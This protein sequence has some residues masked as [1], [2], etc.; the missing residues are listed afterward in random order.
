M[1]NS[2][3]D[4]LVQTRL[5]FTLRQRLA[6]T[7]RKTV[8]SIEAC[9][10]LLGRQIGSGIANMERFDA[11]HLDARQVWLSWPT[12]PSHAAGLRVIELENLVGNG[13]HIQQLLQTLATS[14]A[15]GQAVA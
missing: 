5:P 7:F 8:P 14:K 12:L 3:R 13:G 1:P 4:A 10:T 15:D 2:K 6:K 9:S 11:K